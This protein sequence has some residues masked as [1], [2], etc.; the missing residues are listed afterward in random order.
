MLSKGALEMIAWCAAGCP[1]PGDEPKQDGTPVRVDPVPDAADDA[2]YPADCTGALIDPD[3]GAFLP[4]GPYLSPDDVR[5]MRAELIGQIEELSGL[6]CWP[7]SYR[8]EV[9]TAAVRGPLSALMP[10][11]HHFTGRLSAARA[12]SEAREALAAR[13]WR[14]EGFDDRRA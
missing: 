5:R 8:D 7:D 6:E 11:L 2:D 4:W 14:L 3:G 10:D 12:E 9:L 13:V 1:L